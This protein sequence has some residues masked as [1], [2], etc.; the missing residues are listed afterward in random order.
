M[1]YISIGQHKVRLDIEPIDAHETVGFVLE[2]CR[3][4]IEAAQIKVHTSLDAGEK[5]VMADSIKLQQVMWNLLRNAIKFSPQGGSIFISSTNEGTGSFALEIA[6]EGIGI[7]AAF[8]PFVFEAYQQGEQS[9]KKHLGG[10]GLGLYIAKGLAQSQH[11]TLTAAS[12]GPGL[13]AT[14]RL[15]LDTAPPMAASPGQAVD[16]VSRCRKVVTTFQPEEATDVVA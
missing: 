15:C 11:G 5:L 6:D 1:D 16:E 10:L 8:L 13:G 12:A 9:I 4:E 3:S 14:F 7:D 2:I